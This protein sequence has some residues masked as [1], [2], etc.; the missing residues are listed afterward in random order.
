MLLIVSLLFVSGCAGL[1]GNVSRPDNLSPEQIRAY[2]EAGLD[3]YGCFQ[4]GGP[5]PAGNTT[6]I[7]IP[8][9]SKSNVKFL[10]NC[11]VQMQ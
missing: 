6:W 9:G 1:I 2:N 11:T 7:T 10:P 4:I 8:K 5:P 3:V